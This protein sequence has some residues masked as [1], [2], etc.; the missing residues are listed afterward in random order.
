MDTNSIMYFIRVCELKNLTKAAQELYITQP[1]LSRRILALEDELGVELLKRTSTGITVTEAGNLF[2]NEEKKLMDA[3]AALVNTMRRFKESHYGILRIGSS[4]EFFAEPVFFAAQLMKNYFPNVE[5]S[6]ME[7]SPEQ[8]SEHYVSKKLDIAYGLRY[9]LPKAFDSVTETILKNNLTVLVPK[10]HRLWDAENIKFSDLVREKFVI[11]TRGQDG[12][13]DAFQLLEAQGVS[14]KDARVVKSSK[15]RLFQ[16]AFKGYLALGMELPDDSTAFSPFLRKIRI[17]ESTLDVAD[18]C[19]MYRP[20]S[21]MAERFANYILTYKK[22][23]KTQYRGI[24][25]MHN[26]AVKFKR[27]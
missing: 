4:L 20:S 5:M 13:E 7:V 26:T 2:Y 25:T 10:G 3:Q 22:E 14:M 11:E 18:V 1:T 24:R 17:A 19:I 16:A 27:V 6:L 23:K 8:M 21:D 12:L 15:D 9:M